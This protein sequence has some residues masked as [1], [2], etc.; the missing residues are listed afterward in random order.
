MKKLRN[1]MFVFLLI[2]GLIM[3]SLGLAFNYYQG[4]VGGSNEN[5][6][7]TIEKGFTN[8]QIGEVLKNK[9]LIKSSTIFKTI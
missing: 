2:F 5:V 6:D 9:D 1:L 3:I 8:N 7:V 4:A